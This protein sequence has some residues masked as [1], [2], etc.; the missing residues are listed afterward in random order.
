MC[1]AAGR[2]KA[3]RVL[4]ITV[5]SAILQDCFKQTKPPQSKYA[6][7]GVYFYSSGLL[8]GKRLYLNNYNIATTDA[9]TLAHNVNWLSGGDASGAFVTIFGTDAG[10]NPINSTF[11]TNDVRTG[12]SSTLLRLHNGSGVS[13]GSPPMTKPAVS[14]VAITGDGAGSGNAY[15]STNG[16]SPFSLTGG[17][18]ATAA[19][20]MQ[21]PAN[22]DSNDAKMKG[23]IVTTGNISASDF[24][25]IQTWL[26]SL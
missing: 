3:L 14:S 12:L 18:V 9:F 11:G 2:L 26:E 23:W 21:S 1:S 17:A 20:V 25:S 16:G 15:I 4:S 22:T 10:N 13:A 8:Y 6:A 5:S 7:D 19:L 24:D